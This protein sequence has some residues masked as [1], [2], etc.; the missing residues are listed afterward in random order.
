MSV[1]HPPWALTHRVASWPAKASLQPFTTI[2]DLQ[3]P[4]LSVWAQWWLRYP[5]LLLL[6]YDNSCSDEQ[7]GRQQGRTKLTVSTPLLFLNNCLQCIFFFFMFS[8]VLNT[9]GQ[10]EGNKTRKQT[11]TKP[12][13]EIF[14]SSS[15]SHSWKGQHICIHCIKLYM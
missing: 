7:A 14:S 4:F 1:P 8:F 13:T 3:S 6:N 2:S 11:N 10:R 15:I 5:A 12:Q 9:M